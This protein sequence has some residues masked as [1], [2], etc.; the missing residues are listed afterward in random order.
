MIVGYVK[1]PERD[2]LAAARIK[3]VA[4]ARETLIN[5]VIDELL[6]MKS[7]TYARRLRIVQHFPR[8]CRWMQG[9]KFKT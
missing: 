9:F 1:G 6:S 2:W 8:S 3:R 7:T 5:S 4:R